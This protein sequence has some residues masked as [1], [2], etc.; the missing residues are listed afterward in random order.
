MDYGFVSRTTIVGLAAGLVIGLSGTSEAAGV[1]CAV[2]LNN[3]P[4]GWS[5]QGA[6]GGLDA[7]VA[8]FNPGAAVAGDTVCAIVFQMPGGVGVPP[9]PL[10]NCAICVWSAVRV[11]PVAEPSVSIWFRDAAH[12]AEPSAGGGPSCVT[13]ASA[14]AIANG[15]TLPHCGSIAGW[16]VGAVGDH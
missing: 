14:L 11:E 8:P 16:N 13:R 10:Q 12:S 1:S 2:G 6:G 4:S 7:T 5:L 3:T 15:V 9:P